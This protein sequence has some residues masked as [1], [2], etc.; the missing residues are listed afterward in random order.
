MAIGLVFGQP[1]HL[2]IVTLYNPFISSCN[3]AC[4]QKAHVQQFLGTEDALNKAAEARVLCQKLKNRLHGNADAVSSHSL[5]GGT[6]QNVKNLR[7][8]E[9]NAR[10]SLVSNFCDLS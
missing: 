2:K 7:Q 1:M 10:Y 8:L 4:I 5:G 3:H 6:S 9:V